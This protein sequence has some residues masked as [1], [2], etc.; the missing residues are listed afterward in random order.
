MAKQKI[1]I[2][3]YISSIDYKPA[4]V[5]PRVFFY[6]GLLDTDTFYIQNNFGTAYAQTAFPYFDNYL[7]NLPTTSSLS[8]LFNNEQS[9]YGETPI[10]SLYSEYWST[11]VDLLYNPRTR[12]VNCSAII[13]LANYFKLNLNDI[14][15]WRGNYYH[16]RAINNYNLSNGECT[17]QLLGPIIGDT[18]AY[19]LPGEPCRFDFD[20]SNV[21]T[22]TVTKCDNSITYYGVTFNTTSSLSNGKVITWGTPGIFEGCY[23]ISSSFDTPDLTGSIIYSINDSCEACTSPTTTTTTTF[24]PTTTTTTT[25]PPPK[26]T[27]DFT[28]QF[29]GTVWDVYATIVSGSTSDNLF[30]TGNALGF[31]DAY[32][33]S[34]ERAQS[35][36]DTLTSGTPYH[37]VHTELVSE[38]PVYWESANFLTL[39]VEG[40]SITSNP[41]IISF[42]GNTYTITGFGNCFTK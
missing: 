29:D 37:Q 9:V 19:I 17:L 33:S 30:F 20:I 41:Q 36:S 14:V 16:L 10:N 39:V 28:I 26:G 13:P 25:L 24:S 3:T 2:P 42:G 4:R 18:L 31:S 7:G 23:T 40:Q 15:E 22:W 8:L 27:I 12:L 1:Y 11:Y 5:L 21:A 34:V 35:F 32:C 38:P 6:N